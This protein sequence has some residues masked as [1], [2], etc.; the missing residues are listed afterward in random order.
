LFCA[1][2]TNLHKQPKKEV[3]A[4]SLIKV[5]NQQLTLEQKVDFVNKLRTENNVWGKHRKSHKQQQRKYGLTENE[6]SYLLYKWDV[7]QKN[8]NYAYQLLN[9]LKK[10]FNS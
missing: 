6:F 4:M 10:F 2:Y 5:G 8:D 3:G 7:P 1:Y 9:A